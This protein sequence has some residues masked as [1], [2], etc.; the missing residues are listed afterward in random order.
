[1]FGRNQAKATPI[2]SVASNDAELSQPVIKINES[3]TSEPEDSAYQQLQIIEKPIQERRIEIDQSNDAPLLSTEQMRELLKQVEHVTE[4]VRSDVGLHSTRVQELNSG[5]SD[6][7]HESANSLTE[8][9]ELLIEANNTLESRLDNAEIRLIEQSDRLNLQL[10][11]GRTDL[12]TGLPNRRVFDNTLSKCFKYYSESR[13]PTC[14]LMLDIDN[15]KQFN[16]AHGHQLGDEVLSQIGITLREVLHNSNAI[17]ARYGG[18]EFGVIMP[19]S[20]MFDAKIAAARINRSFRAM[21]IQHEDQDLNITT[22][23][24][25]AELRPQDDLSFFVRRADLALYAAKEAGR[26]RAYW[27]DGLKEL[28]VMHD[29][30]SASQ[31]NEKE[32]VLATPES[33]QNKIKQ[34]QTQTEKYSS[35][36]AAFVNDL[37]RRLTESTRTNAPLSMVLIGID[38]LDKITSKYG[39]QANVLVLNVMKQLLNAVMRDS[40]HVCQID[41]GQYGILLPTADLAQSSLIAERLRKA[42]TKVQLKLDESRTVQFTISTGVTQALPLDEQVNVISRATAALKKSKISGGNQVSVVRREAEEK[43]TTISAT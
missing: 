3:S 13:R 24:G 30:K 39:K 17:V 12:L 18:E 19:G 34:S 31:H 7:M 5:L 6:S 16:D 8:T 1:M 9:I 35:D 11:E 14:L 32:E 22:S 43:E 28:P 25:I 23:I 2:T 4:T 20:E 27:H 42:V 38:Q 10:E 15:F 41:K 37:E 21:N 36:K 26:D 33:A 29:E 40:D